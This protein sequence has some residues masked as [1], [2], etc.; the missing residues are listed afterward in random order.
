M[1]YLKENSSIPETIIELEKGS[2]DRWNN[3][4][5]SGYLELS[6][7]D[8]V[9]FDPYVEK[10]IDGHATLTKIYEAIRG[11][12]KVYRYEMIDPL[13]QVSEQMAVLTF[14][15]ISYSGES[16]QKWNSTEVF[17]LEPS[18]SWK[19]IQSHWSQTQPALK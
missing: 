15:L 12:V 19:I 11:Q 6:A 4:D 1:K 9:Y 14:N 10:R 2:L 16:V 8:V 3:G 13:V 17:L 7:Q 5:P 18:G